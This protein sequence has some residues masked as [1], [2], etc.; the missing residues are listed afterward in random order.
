MTSRLIKLVHMGPS[1]PGGMLTMI[2]ILL[3]SVN[4]NGNNRFVPTYKYFKER[5]WANFCVYVRAVC[6]VLFKVRRCDL[7]QLHT[8]EKGSFYRKYFIS[9][10][11]RWKGVKYVVHMHGA[12]FGIF[13]DAA[14]HVV[15]S[16]VHEFFKYSES[17]VVLSDSW[18]RYFCEKFPDLENIIVIR[19]P[20]ET[21]KESWI[22]DNS[23]DSIKILYSGVF[24]ERKGVYDLISAFG[25][26]DL[27]N[28]NV[29]LFLFGDGE[30]SKVRDAA[31]S[32]SKASSIHVS[33]WMR[34][35]DYIERIKEFQIFA[36]PSYAEGL[37]MS[38]L[39]AIGQGLPVVATRI[40]GIPEAVIDGENG[41]LIEPGDRCSLALRLEVL[42]ND[43]ELRN[44]FS[45]SSWE[46]ANAQFSL[47]HIADQWDDLI[48][49]VLV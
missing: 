16:R 44:R 7:V 10:L 45:R 26:M 3:K 42:C 5:Y 33:P 24:G 31:A 34:H 25:A 28:R 49:K 20:C 1:S 40:G 36:L 9:R 17:L 30:I 14:S 29:E 32:S 23:S 35:S 46:R 8:A 39:E 15:Q 43:P 22:G 27:M 6:F 18:R 13:L 48:A 19:N 41:Y 4:K 12:R 37:P 2:G 38:I 11:L 21:I 47:V